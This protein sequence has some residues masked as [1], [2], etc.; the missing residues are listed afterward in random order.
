MQQSVVEAHRE[1]PQIRLIGY[2]MGMDC[3][4][5]KNKAKATKMTA[6]N[7]LMVLKKRPNLKDLMGLRNNH[8]KFAKKC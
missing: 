5:A 1:S 2:L 3:L 4:I 8:L 6:K 7:N